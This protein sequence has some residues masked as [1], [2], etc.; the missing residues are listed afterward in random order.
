MKSLKA[1][2]LLKALVHRLSAY[3]NVTVKLNESIY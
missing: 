2:W 1:L 3:F